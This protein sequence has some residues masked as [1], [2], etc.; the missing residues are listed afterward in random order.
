MGQLLRSETRLKK[1]L[2]AETVGVMFWSL[3]AGTLVEANDSFLTIMGYSRR[4][5][6]DHS[7]TRQQLTPP[8]HIDVSVAEV[9]CYPNEPRKKFR[10]SPAQSRTRC[11]PPTTGYLF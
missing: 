3:S 10:R 8:E 1:V 2:E 5:V 11:G 4:D 7:L 9:L 6:E